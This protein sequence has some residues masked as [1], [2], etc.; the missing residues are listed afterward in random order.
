MLEVADRYIDEIKADGLYWDEME[1]VGYGAPLITHNI[2]DGFS[3]VLDKKTYTID[4]EVG[5]TTLLGEGHRLAVIDR[6]RAKGGTLMGNGPTTTKDILAK[7]P[8]RM[9]EIQHN[10]TWCYEG[11]LD[12]PLGYA[13]S[14][15]DFGNWVRAIRLATLLV[16]TTYKYE[17]E[18]SPYVFPFTPIEL[19][20]G[21]LLGKE[22]IITIHSGN[23]G[24]PGERCLVQVRHFNKEGKLT[25]KDFVTTVTYEARTK[26]ELEE[27]E[28]TILERLPITLDVRGGSALITG[29]R[30]EPD[31]ITL[32]IQAPAGAQLRVRSGKFAI[33]PW[34]PIILSQDNSRRPLLVN[35]EGI[36][37]V[38]LKCHKPTRV[39]ILPAGGNRAPM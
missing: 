13:S 6:V 28:A 32:S 34:M 24:W 7:K 36:I 1:A 31:R 21:Y 20:S 12:T 22:R 8:Q 17:H 3:C 18:I 2:P 30:Y 15:M 16:G 33:K 23:Y 39:T 26:V 29:V 5:I 37:S 19:H 35:R 25:D 10:D 38:N 4:H 27:G 9:I 14:R 11:N